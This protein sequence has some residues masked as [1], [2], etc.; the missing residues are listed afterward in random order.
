MDDLSLAVAFVAGMLSFFS[1]CVFPLVPAYV[2]NLSGVALEASH[3]WKRAF[4]HALAFVI[5]FSLVFISL[6]ALTGLA[7]ASLSSYRRILGWVGGGILI[8]L[9]LHLM[10]VLRLNILNY[11]RRPD[12]HAEKKPG[13]IRSFLLGLGF[14]LGW[15]PCVGPILGGIL[16]LTLNSL[17]LWSGVRLL[18]VYSLGLGVPFLLVSL[19]LAPATR[20]VPRLGRY[21]WLPS[22]LGGLLLVSLGILMLTNHLVIF[23]RYF[24][25]WNWGGQ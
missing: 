5:G 2:A 20:L 11:E 7:G 15:T 16:T 4:S 3:P 22:L 14:S 1:P 18:S 12:F 21:L 19:V 13:H 10:G 9:G 8:L 23:N 17:T 24:D 25:F 6:G